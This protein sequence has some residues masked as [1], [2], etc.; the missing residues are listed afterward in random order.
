MVVSSA[1]LSSHLLVEEGGLIS[2]YFQSSGPNRPGYSSDIED[3]FEAD[4]CCLKRSISSSRVVG[5]DRECSVEPIRQSGYLMFSSLL[6]NSVCSD[7]LG[8]FKRWEV[9]FFQTLD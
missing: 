6:A 7:R 8:V 1:S 9:L 2:S 3:L 5:T 4:R